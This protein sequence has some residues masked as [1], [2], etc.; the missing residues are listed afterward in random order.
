MEDKKNFSQFK[1]NPQ[2]LVDELVLVTRYNKKYFSRI[3]SAGK[4]TFKIHNSDIVFKISNG[5]ERGV[6]TLSIPFCELVTEAYKIETQK[7]WAISNEIAAL[8]NL[9]KNEVASL[10][11]E[12]LRLISDI[13]KSKNTQL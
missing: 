12:K 1:D 6:C 13:I 2:G 5:F 3:I 7:K 8:S 4:A 10:S 11:I 9:I